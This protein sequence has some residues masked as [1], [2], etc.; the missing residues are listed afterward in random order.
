MP[1]ML[2][3]R[4]AVLVWIVWPATGAAQNFKMGFDAY[5][6]GDYAT[7]LRE[8]MPLAEQGNAYAQ[9]N[10]GVMYESGYG[11]VHD[12]QIA[13]RFFYNA[14][15]Q[16]HTQPQVNLRTMAENGYAEAQYNLGKMLAQGQ[17]ISQDLTEAAHWLQAAAAQGHVDAK[18]WLNNFGSF[19][20]H[21]R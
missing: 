1:M 15:I 2:F 8:W 13:A 20:S 19:F 18:I 4:C 7:A 16:G 14:A 21:N 11:V 12:Y 9:N 5:S 17:G 3:I 10:L 6:I